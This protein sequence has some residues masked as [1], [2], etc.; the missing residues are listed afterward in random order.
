MTTQGQGPDTEVSSD[1]ATLTW[2]EP[3]DE[4][5][6]AMADAGRSDEHRAVDAPRG[7][8]DG[9]VLHEHRAVELAV[10]LPLMKRKRTRSYSWTPPP[11]AASNA[12]DMSTIPAG[13]LRDSFDAMQKD[14]IPGDSGL[15]SNTVYKVTLTIEDDLPSP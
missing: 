1:A 5:S 11:R 13:F 8:P 7:V 9:R 2:G 12:E 6:G 14:D 15:T 4:T 3:A 10:P